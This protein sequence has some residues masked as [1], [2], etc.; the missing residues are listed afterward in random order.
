MAPESTTP[1]HPRKDRSVPSRPRL[2]AL[3]LALSFLF[4]A[5]VPA[6][7]ANQG[8]AD[9]VF[10][11][12]MPIA[13][14][15]SN[16]DASRF[17]DFGG[18]AASLPYLA[19]LGVTAVWMNPP[20]PSPAYHGYQH[21]RA[22]QLNPRFGTEAEFIAFIEAAHAL[23]IK[24][25]VDFVAYGISHDSPW[26]QDAY[27][28]PSSPYDS[29]LAFTN[30]S[31]T[32]YFGSTYNTWNGA[33]VGHIWWDLRN[34]NSVDLVTTWAQHW[35]DPNGD[36]D[37]NDGLD[38]YRLDHV[39]QTYP[40]G[41]DGWGYHIDSFWAP[42]R[43][44]LRDVNPDVFVFAEQ[45]DWGSQGVELLEGLDAA[46]TKPFEFAARD[47]LRWEYASALYNG[48]GAATAAL[49]NS[50]YPG[51]LIATI[52]NHDVDRLATNIGDGFA[53]GKAAAAVL[54]TQPFPPNLYHGDEI[55]MRG[56]KNT[57]YSGDAADIPMREPFKWN[58]IAGPPMTN[59]DVLNA[60]AYAGR[61]S[62]NN[63]GRSVQEQLNVPGSLLEAYRQL[64][65]ARKSSVALRRGAYQPVTASDGGV[66]AFVRDHADQQVLVVINVTG[67]ARNIQL[68]LAGYDIP[69]GT[70]Q[71]VSLLG[72]ASPTALTDA[73][74]AAWPL[75]LVAYGYR[76]F[77]LDVIAPPPP[78]ALVDGRNLT[79]AL[80]A[81]P[82]QA[83]Q[84]SPT[85]LG[86]NVSEADQLLARVSGDSLFVNI[87]GNL[88]TDGT[89]LALL[90]DLAPGGQNV[91]DT[92]GFSPPPSGPEYL[93]G[94]RLDAGFEPD[95]MLF[96]NAYAGAIYVDRYDLL[97]GGGVAKDYIGQGAVGS[98]NGF[99]SGGINPGGIQ[100]ALDNTNLTGVSDADVANATAATT[101]FEF[102]L[103]LS[104]LGHT[105][106]DPRL[107]A[108]ILETSGNV[109]NQ[110]LP[111]L[112][113]VAGTLGVAPDLTIYAGD[114]FLA[115]DSITAVNGDGGSADDLR[116]TAGNSVITFRL[117]ADGN[118]E[119]MVLDVRGH[120]LRR[121]LSNQP[122][123]AGEHKVSWDGR[124]EA[125]R[126]AASGV[127]LFRLS[128]DG[129]L[130]QGRISLIR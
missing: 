97:T 51:T 116:V 39:W 82:F 111:P 68:D 112:P 33:T 16:N 95:V 36:G 46:F 72:G 129:R 17:G 41:T 21:G 52:G 80:A 56:A 130:A 54:L 86:D 4:P 12:F 59:Y 125:G 69:G 18:M 74:K 128:A 92:S 11:H 34:P 70:T 25:F 105:G 2:F 13:W 23:G 110:W 90:L 1:P 29:W 38:G 122:L 67:G 27:G 87:T 14:R 9:E 106:G 119:L 19:D 44:A 6:A 28:R 50:P 32:Q 91:L 35:L 61:I 55:G 73:N 103:P 15:D 64:I 123:A 121:L 113:N 60:A 3:I 7:A 71:P 118:V 48:I 98:G 75:S 10:Y 109:S 127:Y 83:A 58:A 31:N 117:P 99:L 49:A 62:Q 102:Y 77:D 66:W 108:F 30:G 94:L 96:V 124:D 100:V 40:N 104:A 120:V 93:T 101:G 57:A 115:M 22:D 76:I 42:W 78:A 79:S 107:A 53:K 8:V 5:A 43:Q 20:F 26:Y 126:T 45:A 114:Q 81:F 65:A 24:V 37:F 89:G 84:A 63:D 47:A 85:H 88:A